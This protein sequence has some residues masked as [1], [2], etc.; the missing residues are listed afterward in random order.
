MSGEN[1]DQNLQTVVHLWRKSLEFVVDVI[2]ISN[3]PFTPQGRLMVYVGLPDQHVNNDKDMKVLEKRQRIEIPDKSLYWAYASSSK[4]RILEEVWKDWLR[5]RLDVIMEDYVDV[6]T[7]S[8]GKN[9]AYT[10][11]LSMLKKRDT[12]N[13]SWRTLTSNK[14]KGKVW[15][16]SEMDR[17]D[18]AKNK[19]KAIHTLMLRDIA[20]K[21]L[22]IV[23]ETTDSSSS[24]S[25]DI[26]VNYDNNNYNT[27]QQ[28]TSNLFKLQMKQ[29]PLVNS[30]HCSSNDTTDV[31]TNFTTVPLKSFDISGP[32][33][34]IN[35]ENNFN[36]T[37]D[38][39][40]LQ[41]KLIQ[42]L[43]NDA[44]IAKKN[45]EKMI[46][47]ACLT[48]EEIEENQR[49]EDEKLE[50]LRLDA[51]RSKEEKLT[52]FLCKCNMSKNETILLKHDVS[53]NDLPT[54]NEK[55]LIKM[56]LFGMKNMLARRRFLQAIDDEFHADV[57]NSTREKIV[58]SGSDDGE[59]GGSSSG[60]SSSGG[61][62]SGGSSSDDDD[63]DE[64]KKYYQ[65]KN[66][67]MRR[68][69]KK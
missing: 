6:A 12:I 60:G 67:T 20:H 32:K 3:T 23:I 17:K 31:T 68:R 61:S 30:T 52:L 50:Q 55:D 36:K 46:D 7:K 9:V 13:N 45:A 26:V 25:N 41:L 29:P 11:L 54:L 65:R 2:D 37:K 66:I 1:N 16:K 38:E 57:N 8:E 4:R 42:P 27:E 24:S 21:W 33:G 47:F 53:Y 44:T 10:E 63:N 62:S 40:Q 28:V 59:S 14:Q 64:M 35:R 19:A 18:D 51:S 48:V 58:F 22:S 15:S 39:V 56:N 69:R 43:I 34:F 49:I 5:E